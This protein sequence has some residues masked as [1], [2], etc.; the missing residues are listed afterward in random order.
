[1]GY[2]AVA[3]NMG[4]DSRGGDL[5]EFLDETYPAKTCGVGLP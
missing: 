4:L 5:L 1:M 2:N 3:G